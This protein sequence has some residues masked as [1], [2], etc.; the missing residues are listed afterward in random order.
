MVVDVGFIGRNR[1]TQPVGKRP[2]PMAVNF[3]G[4][5]LKQHEIAME[6]RNRLANVNSDLSAAMSS[7]ETSNKEID[8]LNARIAELES[9]LKAEREKNARSAA[10]PSQQR[11]HRRSRK[12]KAESE[13]ETDADQLK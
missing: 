3:S 4:D 10:E 12:D 8:R 7:L 5:A 13:Q 9:E 2:R 11:Q 6:Y 1:I